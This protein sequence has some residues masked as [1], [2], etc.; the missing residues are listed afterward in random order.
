ML[1]L[2]C[3]QLFILK[4]FKCSLPG[5]PQERKNF[6]LRTLIKDG[7]SEKR[8]LM[9]FLT[10]FALILKTQQAHIALLVEGAFRVIV[11]Q[12]QATVWD[13]SVTQR[14]REKIM[15]QEIKLFEICCQHYSNARKR[16]GNWKIKYSMRRAF[17]VRETVHSMKKHLL[18]KFVPLI[19]AAQ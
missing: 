13:K 11:H 8:F 12:E 17:R 4:I 1:C 2:L 3:F 10:F 15:F 16:T 6:T 18:K 14:A 19:Y 5:K 9:H 7:F